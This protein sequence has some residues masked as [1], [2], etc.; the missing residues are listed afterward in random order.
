ME[1]VVIRTEMQRGTTDCAVACLS[2][3][4]GVPYADVRRGVRLRGSGMSLRQVLAFAKAQNKAL[5]WATWKEGED[6][7]GI[8][9]VWLQGDEGDHAVIMVHGSVYDPA[10]GDWWTDDEAFFA[11]HAYRIHGTLR[12]W[13]A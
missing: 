11:S 13:E 12:R 8:A 1:P 4:L 7:A 3:L 5:R 6:I 9:M 10:T 2:M